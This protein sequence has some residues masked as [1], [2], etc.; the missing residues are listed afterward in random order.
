[1]P[2]SFANTRLQPLYSLVLAVLILTGCEPP[3]APTP[4]ATPLTGPLPERFFA[5]LKALEAGTLETPLTILHFGDSHI[6]AD[7]FSKTLRRKLQARFGGAGRGFVPPGEPYQHFQADGYQITMSDGWFRANSHFDDPGPYGITGVRLDAKKTGAKIT[8]RAATPADHAIIHLLAQPTGGRIK[9]ETD[10]GAIYPHSTRA[11]T[12]QLKTLT[13]PG[14]I[15]QLS[16]T[17]LDSPVT[18]L[19]W[20][21]EHDTPGIRYINLGLPGAGAAIINRWHPHLLKSELEALNPDL[22]ILGYGTNEG[23][24]DNLNLAQYRQNYQSLITRLRQAAPQADLLILTAP[25]G[26]RRA[27][28][29]PQGNENNEDNAAPCAPLSPAERTRYHALLNKADPALTRWHDPPNLK[30]VAMIQKR[31]AESQGITLWDW[32]AAM[33]GSCAIHTWATA[34]PALA[35]PDHVHLTEAGSEVSANR[36]Y[37]ALIYGYQVTVDQ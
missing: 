27:H 1:M 10:T 14:P 28:Y 5:K 9:I 34:S 36:F 37:D 2:P 35:Y 30:P 7:R 11:E 24:S 20:G 16:L 15:S 17:T 3:S 22:I 25:D 33:G 29:A 21:F 31:L 32:A 8:L 4:P 12:A 26:A 19:G 23:F 18:I 13:I 6:A